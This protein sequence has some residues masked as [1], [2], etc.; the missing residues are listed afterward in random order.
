MVSTKATQLFHETQVIDRGLIRR[1]KGWSYEGLAILVSVTSFTG[2]VI[3]LRG[4]DG[5]PQEDWKYTHVTRNTIIAAISTIAHTSLLAAVTIS[6]SQNKWTWISQQA[7]KARRLK[8]LK[9]F[10]DASRGV[11][12]S[13]HLLAIINF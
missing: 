13:L 9:I 6:I 3:A 11:K 5:K 10:D 4:F 7:G 2:L 1:L 8:D 12:G